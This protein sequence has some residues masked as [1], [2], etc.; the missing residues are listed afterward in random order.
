MEATLLSGHTIQI[1]EKDMPLLELYP[2]RAYRINGKLRV[3][4]LGSRGAGRPRQ[5]LQLSRLI[6]G[7]P[8][9]VPIRHENGNTLDL[10]RANLLVGGRLT[11]ASSPNRGR[12]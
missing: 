4:A 7:A 5:M 12:A 6:T 11:E 3:V 1:D 9:R 8:A 2:W 10:R